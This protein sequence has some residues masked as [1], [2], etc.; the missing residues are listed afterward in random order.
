MDQAQSFNLV[1]YIQG[2]YGFIQKQAL[3][4]LGQQHG[5]PGTL[6]FTT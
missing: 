2:R 5:N 3:G 1:F 4:L 6:A